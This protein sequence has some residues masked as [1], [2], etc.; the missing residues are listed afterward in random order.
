M[1]ITETCSYAQDAWDSAAAHPAPGH[2]GAPDW[3]K[4]DWDPALGAPCALHAELARRVSF[5]ESER[6][7][8]LQRLM[9]G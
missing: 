6:P 4:A 1:Q 9:E 3:S 2:G 8:S 7:L 5:R